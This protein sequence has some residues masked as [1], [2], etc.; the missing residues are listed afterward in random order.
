MKKQIRKSSNG[1]S[2]FK[3]LSLGNMISAW[4]GILFGLIYIALGLSG[5]KIKAKVLT[6]FEYITIAG[7]LASAIMGVA[8]AVEG[9]YYGDVFGQMTRRNVTIMLTVFMSVCL[10]GVFVGLLGSLMPAFFDD[11]PEAAAKAATILQY[12]G[13]GLFA[14]SWLGHAITSSIIV[15]KAK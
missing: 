5:V 14:L 4:V 15:A 8:Q 6:V 1:M 12:A 13:I 10:F 3:R 11:M 7:V 9:R 2:I